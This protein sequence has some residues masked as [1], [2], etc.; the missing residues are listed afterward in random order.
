VVQPIPKDHRSNS[1]FSMAHGS[2]HKCYEIFLHSAEEIFG[3]LLC[4][5]FNGIIT[6][7]KNFLPDHSTRITLLKKMMTKITSTQNSHVVMLPTECL[8]RETLLI[9]KNHTSEFCNARV[10]YFS[11]ICRG[12]FWWLLCMRLN[13]ITNMGNF[14]F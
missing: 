11:F 2:A 12:N 5:L 7:K 13:C 9:P 3:G 8:S 10:L 1:Q 6:N 14:F 4:M